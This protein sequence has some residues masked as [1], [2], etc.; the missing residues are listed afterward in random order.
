M[1]YGIRKQH[2]SSPEDLTILKCYCGWISDELSA[3]EMHERGIP[4]YCD[5]CSKTGLSFIRFAPHE[6]EEALR[7]L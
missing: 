1:D 4:W 7:R 3:D 6:R 2:V 5:R